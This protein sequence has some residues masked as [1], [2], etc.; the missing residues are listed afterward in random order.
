[1]KTAITIAFAFMMCISTSAQLLQDLDYITSFNEG[2]AAVK[3]G[4]QWGFIDQQ[5]ELVIDFRDDLAQMTDKTGSKTKPEFNN[6]RAIIS[7]SKDGITFYG[8]I[9]KTGEEVIKCEYVNT[10]GFK[11]G[12]ALVMHFSKEVVG[13]NNLLGKDVVSYQIEEYVI[14]V[15]GKALT[16]ALNPRNYVPSKMKS[17]AAPE[18]T[19]RFIGD[20]MV[21]V[22]GSDKKWDVYK[23]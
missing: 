3:K 9:D 8:F 2:L 21:A 15:N 10:S 1:M 16:P 7:T 11:N 5:G 20:N 14:D 17:G 6:E 13:K 23:F 18:F 4:D 19:A 12:H 22:E